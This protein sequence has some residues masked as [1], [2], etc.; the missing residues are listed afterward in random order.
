MSTPTVQPVMKPVPPCPVHAR[1]LAAGAL[2]LAGA[3]AASTPLP[4]GPAL[5]ETRLA[6]P[7]LA[8]RVRGLVLPNV[9]LPAEAQTA[10]APPR[11]VVEIGE[12][13]PRLRLAP[14]RRVEPR[15]PP[16]G[17]LWGRTRIGLRCV[18][19]ER[20][21]QVWLP[22]V[23]KVFAPAPVPVRALPAGTVLAAEH[24]QSAEID[25]AAHA[26]PP[27]GRAGDLVGRTLA[28]ALQP[29]DAVRAADLRLRQWFAA[30]TTVQVLA[31]GNGFAVGGEGQALNAGIEGQPVR[32]RTDAGRVLI[33]LP[34]A[35]RRVEVTL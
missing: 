1:L 6:E 29:G 21:W 3:A 15:L 18:E 31:R 26:Q 7:S 17:R 13:D 5:A 30:G 4:A 9:T 11:V 35:E 22:V 34:V 19:G 8:E 27:Y 25:W 12:I 20:P 28:R 24:L 14:C 33:G 10:A 23:V 16:P 32:V 2:A